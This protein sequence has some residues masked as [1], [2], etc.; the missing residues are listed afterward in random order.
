MPRCPKHRHCRRLDGERVFKPRAVP[1]HACEVTRLAAAE[2]EA[3]RLCDLEGK[4]Q[5]AAGEAMGVSRGTVQ[6]LLEAARRKVTA[7]LLHNG[8]LAID[9]PKE[10]S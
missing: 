5:A 4:T 2:F 10:M 8:A 3:L 1:M 7:M 9:P 6:R